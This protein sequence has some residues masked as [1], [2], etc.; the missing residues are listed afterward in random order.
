MKR[1]KS[2]TASSFSI[3]VTWKTHGARQWNKDTKGEK[4]LGEPV[5]IGM[6]YFNFVQVEVEMPMRYTGVKGIPS[7]GWKY[8]N[9]AWRRVVS[10]IG[11]YFANATEVQ[12]DCLNFK[13]II[14]VGWRN[15][16]PNHRTCEV[17][18]W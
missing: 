11:S 7:G 6:I 12:E 17:K 1:K 18:E 4:Y 8:K 13:T 9:L 15:Q 16:K 3:S 2:N 10:D 5:G 14:L